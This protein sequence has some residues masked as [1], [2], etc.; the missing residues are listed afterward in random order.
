MRG[1]S[2]G[3]WLPTGTSARLGILGVRWKSEQNRI[4]IGR[5]FRNDTARLEELFERYTKE[6]G[7][8]SGG[9]GGG[10]KGSGGAVIDLPGLSR[11]L[12][13]IHAAQHSQAG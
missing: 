5:R 3:W 13:E 11:S 10:E 12:P 4:Y 9:E 7:E 2:P 8:G 6:D 1:Q